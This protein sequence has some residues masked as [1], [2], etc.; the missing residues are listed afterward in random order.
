MRGAPVRG[1]GGSWGGPKMVRAGQAATRRGMYHVGEYPPA[2]RA[3]M[4]GPVAAAI[5][6]LAALL[7]VPAAGS[8]GDTPSPPPCPAALDAKA[9]GDGSILLAWTPVSGAEGY[10]VL[11]GEPRGDLRPLAVVQAPAT[12]YEDAG[13]RPGATYRYVVHSLD[14]GPA[15]CLEA[16][17][18]AFPYVAGFATALAVIAAAMAGFVVVRA[19]A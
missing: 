11:R 14:A 7:T 8:S 18:T 6:A 2:E 16:R 1:A 12:T 3:S 10:V 9:K 17:A 15:A 5:V 13:A 4:R 19:R